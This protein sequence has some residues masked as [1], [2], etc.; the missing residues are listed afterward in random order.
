MGRSGPSTAWQY[1][2]RP[3]P[4]P[5]PGGG[6]GR[7]PRGY[8]VREE[9]QQQQQQQ[10]QQQ[11]ERRHLRPLHALPPSWRAFFRRFG[12]HGW[13]HLNGCGWNHI[14]YGLMG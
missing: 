3:P 12:Y 6:E 14:L 5:V 8:G 9:W 1:P 10:Q 13:G 7:R 2:R 11:E 4:T